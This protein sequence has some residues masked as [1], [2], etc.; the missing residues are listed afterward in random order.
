MT[1]FD[2]DELLRDARARH[3]A[4]VARYGRLGRSGAETATRP[5]SNERY[6]C[7]GPLAFLFNGRHPDDVVEDSKSFKKIL[8]VFSHHAR[9]RRFGKGSGWTT[10]TLKSGTRFR[11]SYDTGEAK[12]L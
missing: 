3:R 2:P 5:R 4:A 12:P 1:E 6:H 10:V 7:T 8:H 9:R 11:F